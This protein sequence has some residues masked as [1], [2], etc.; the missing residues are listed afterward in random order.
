ME[1]LIISPSSSSSLVS[2]SQ[3]NP[4]PTLQQKLQFLL[5]S[6]PDWWVYAIFWQASHDDNG[7]LYLSFGEGHF[8][9]TKETSPK[10]LTI[11]TKNKFL[12]KTPT[13]DNINDAEWFYV[14][15]LTRSF[16]VNNNSSSNSTSCSSSSSLP[17]K[18][19]ALGSVLWQNNRHELQFYNCERSNEAH[20][21]GIETLICIPTQNGVVEMGSY[22]TIKQNWNLVQHVKS[23]F[24]TSPDPVTIQI[25]DDHTIS[26]ADIGIVAGIQ[27]T[28]KRKQITQTAP[29]KNDNYVDSEHS[30]SDC[31]TLPTATTPTASEPKK[32]GRKPVL[33]RET[34][35]NHVEAER[36]RREKLNHRFYALRAVVPN[37]SR[38]DKA[39][40][41]SDAVAY[42]NELKAKI[43]DLESQQPR[44]SN[45]KMKT[46]MT[47]TL[48]N[49]SA[50]TTSTVVD[51]SGSGSRL[52]LGPLGLEV[53]VRIVGPDAM[54]RVQSENVNH[55]GA[56]LMGALRDL[57]FQVHHASMSCVNDLMLQDV[58]VK[59]PNGMRSEES[60]KSAIIMRLD[61]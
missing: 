57:E 38:M 30:D 27:E 39:S 42:I 6:Q 35:I 33:G 18:S 8:Q 11:P 44:D 31:P 54:V 3:E 25:L 14:M 36:Q 56:R 7:N 23:L 47:D 9:G 21:H 5:Q 53:D 50:T 41:L 58:V 15:S 51:Q 37:V 60:L 59:L 19:F 61:Q 29:S 46:E 17:G 13:N 2:L 43:E 34:P 55:P 16:A 28:K 12:M 10:S 49:Q 1:E 40:L 22:D 52:G 4:T 48:D 24:H 45:K 20:V 26:F 32:R